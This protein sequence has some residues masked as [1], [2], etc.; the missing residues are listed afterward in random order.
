MNPDSSCISKEKR[1]AFKVMYSKTAWTKP[2]LKYV[3]VLCKIFTL[4]LLNPKPYSDNRM[5]TC[6]P[7]QP[8]THFI[9]CQCSLPKRPRPL[10]CI[11]VPHIRHNWSVTLQADV[12]QNTIELGETAG[13]ELY[14]GVC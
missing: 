7:P 12:Q 14:P 3:C 11:T 2:S 1:E 4:W 10:S 13:S 6:T 9:H 8:H 5:L